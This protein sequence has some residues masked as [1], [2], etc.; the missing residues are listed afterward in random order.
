ML[1]CAANAFAQS[2]P[3]ISVN[4][5]A[6]TDTN[7]LHITV[8][9]NAPCY[10]SA[11]GDGVTTTV[12]GQTIQIVAR[13]TCI[14]LTPPPP[15]TFTVDVGPLSPGQYQIQYLASSGATPPGLLASVPVQVSSAIPTMTWPWLLALVVFIVVA[16]TRRRQSYS[17]RVA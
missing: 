9:T 1:L 17:R 10:P 16:A 3:V 13:L 8:A 7:V 6:P 5:F 14:A 15:F 11:P 12:S 4:P 2:T